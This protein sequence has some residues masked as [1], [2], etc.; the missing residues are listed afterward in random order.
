M[1]LPTLCFFLNAYHSRLL[2]MISGST[3]E[4]LKSLFVTSWTAKVNLIRGAIS[5]I[6]LK[7]IKFLVVVVPRQTSAASLRLAQNTLRIA[8]PAH[9]RPRVFLRLQFGRKL[10]V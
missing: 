1:D 6:V 3:W 9:A 2:K 10:L 8:N 5:S 4:E 7:T